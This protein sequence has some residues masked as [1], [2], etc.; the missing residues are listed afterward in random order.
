MQADWDALQAKMAIFSLLMGNSLSVRVSDCDH[1]WPEHSA[2]PLPIRL[3]QKCKTKMAFPSADLLRGP[4]KAWLSFTSSSLIP[5]SG[6][7][8]RTA[9]PLGLPA[10]SDLWTGRKEGSKMW[11][12]VNEVLG[13]FSP[14]SS[15]CLCRHYV[16]RCNLKHVSYGFG[17]VCIFFLPEFGFARIVKSRDNIPN[18][19]YFV[20]LLL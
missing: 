20:S 8:K 2:L 12:E 1:W 16:E 3:E 13:T 5:R 6:L 9:Q 15:L 10:L 17:S 11:R 18:R 19:K 7:L 14:K 4:H